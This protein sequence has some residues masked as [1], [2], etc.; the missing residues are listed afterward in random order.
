MRLHQ[1]EL[2]YGILYRVSYVRVIKLMQENKH[3]MVV[4]TLLIA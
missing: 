1:H 4:P 2:T 3:R